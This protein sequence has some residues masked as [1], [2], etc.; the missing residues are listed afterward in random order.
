M[1]G[2]GKVD[3]VW[4]GKVA[5]S[6][7]TSGGCRRDVMS[8]AWHGDPQESGRVGRT[9]GG[10]ARVTSV[11]PL[12]LQFSNH[13]PRKSVHNHVLPSWK[14]P[15]PD[16][17]PEGRDLYQKMGKKRGGVGFTWGPGSMLLG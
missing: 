16:G 2:C 1:P 10:C 12:Y 6:R 11:E 8:T 13:S 4:K 17:G 7:G 3:D 9:P 15:R 5:G 14:H